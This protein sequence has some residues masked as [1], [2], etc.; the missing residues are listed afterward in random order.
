MSVGEGQLPV[1]WQWGEGSLQLGEGER[2]IA[3]RLNSGT[4]KS[5]PWSGSS[6]D[7]CDLEAGGDS[8]KRR[9]R[10]GEV[11]APW[12]TLRLRRSPGDRVPAAEGMEGNRKCRWQ[13]DV[14]R[15][16]DISG[17]EC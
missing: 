10:R 4:P 2:G 3:K 5:S 14:G 11:S 13:M 6:S 12:L 15:G 8:I 7:V 16:F 1:S 17:C 9:E